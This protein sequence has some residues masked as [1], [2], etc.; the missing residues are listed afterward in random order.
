MFNFHHRVRKKMSIILCHSMG[1]VPHV[2]ITQPSLTSDF[3]PNGWAAA[4]FHGYRRRVWKD[5]Q[6]WLSSQC[7][8]SS[9]V[10]ADIVRPVYHFIRVSLPPAACHHIC[11]YPFVILNSLWLP[12]QFACE[13][14]QYAV[15]C[16][17]VSQDWSGRVNNLNVITVSIVI[18]S[19]PVAISCSKHK[20]QDKMLAL[21]WTSAEIPW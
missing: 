6:E 1:S 10:I 18:I 15:V 2:F 9:D 7:L 4:C 19:H 8:K 3:S 20:F 13:T 12:V 11:T 5:I 21:T 16:A 14:T 17:H